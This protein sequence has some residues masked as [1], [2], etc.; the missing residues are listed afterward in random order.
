MNW[1]V[2]LY[3]HSINGILADEMGLGKTIQSIAFIA[4]LCETENLWGPYL[5][6]APNSVVHN[7]CYEFEQFT[8]AIKVL[9][10]WGQQK[11]REVLR[12]FWKSQFLY[13]SEGE[14]HVMVT[15]YSTFQTDE[16]HFKKMKWQFIILDEAHAIKNSSR[17][18]MGCG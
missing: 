16:R 2:N 10:Y 18:R 12:R 14:F 8:P 5:V 7:W 4:H 1:L 15:S 13:S 11:D 9:P 17:F 6:V 3:D